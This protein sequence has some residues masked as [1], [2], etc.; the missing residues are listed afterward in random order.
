MDNGN[1]RIR[2]AAYEMVAL[3][4]LRQHE[5]N[6]NRG[7]V[8]VIAESIEENG[9]YGAVVA[10]R[11]TGKVLAGNHRL[12]A[13]KSLGLSEVPVI[14]LDV[15]DHEALRILLA[16]NQLAKLATY[17]DGVLLEVLRELEHTGSNLRGTGYED[18]DLQRLAQELAGD[19]AEN[20]R[21]AQDQKADDDEA[22]LL[23]RWGVIVHVETEDEQTELLLRFNGRGLQ[24]RALMG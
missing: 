13:A 6:P 20:A 8:L 11:S 24:V 1:G 9:F 2:N 15:D 7:D 3:D 12:Q 19:D 10:Q 14:W 17:D 18:V 23:E 22:E 21:P 5:R 16:D 4:Q